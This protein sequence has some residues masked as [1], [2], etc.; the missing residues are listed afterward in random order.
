M[1]KPKAKVYLLSEKNLRQWEELIEE[2]QALFLHI[3]SNA[4]IDL[5]D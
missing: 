4:Q 5:D 3:Y 1:E 2:M